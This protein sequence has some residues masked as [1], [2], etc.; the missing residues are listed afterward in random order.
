MNVIVINSAPGVGKTTLL[1]LLEDKLS[2]GYAVI[3]GDEVGRTIPKINS[4]DWLNL[5]QDNIVACAKNYKEYNTKALLVSFVFP[6][7]ER[8]QRLS[9]LL[10]DV[11][12]VYHLTLICDAGELEKRIR[13]RNTQKLISIPRAIELNADIER[14]ASYYAV[15]TTKKTT[16]EIADIVCDK[17]IEIEG[18]GPRLQK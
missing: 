16:E 10:K 11:G 9:N 17:I 3:D 2:N 12:R 18:R 6:T 8:L 13:I 1:K 7:P 4:T 14:L 15:D 5:I